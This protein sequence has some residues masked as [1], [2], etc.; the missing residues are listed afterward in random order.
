ML[1]AK[2]IHKEKFDGIQ[3]FLDL[4][5]ISKKVILAGGSLRTLINQED[6]V[7]DYDLFFMGAGIKAIK[8]KLE[9]KIIDLGGEKVF[10]CKKDELRSFMLN[11]MK[12]QFI[13]IQGKIYNNPFDLI[14]QFDINA[15]K[16]AWDGEY[17]YFGKESVADV[18][19]KHITINVVTYPVAT[20]KRIVKYS[21]KG[22]KFTLA[23]KELV[24]QVSENAVD[25]DADI[26]YID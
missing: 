13:S 15:G 16:F 20:I 18:I 25:M 22:Y 11:S 24:K 21:E 17:L 2:N 19:H 26:V 3:D 6:E 1:K 14:S 10:Q 5:F 7:Q 23:A 12:I 4:G 8:D 9:K